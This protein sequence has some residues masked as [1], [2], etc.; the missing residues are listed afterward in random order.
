V[1]SRVGYPTVLISLPYSKKNNSTVLSGL[2][3]IVLAQASNAYQTAC[4]KLQDCVSCET[5]FCVL[6]NFATLCCLN[7]DHMLT[8]DVSQQLGGSYPVFK[9]THLGLTEPSCLCFLK[10]VSRSQSRKRSK[11][12]RYYPHAMRLAFKDSR[13]KVA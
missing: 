4:A 5:G 13:T 11:M 8:G 6:C 9:N 10:S 1:P 7:L 12:F 2:S 3:E